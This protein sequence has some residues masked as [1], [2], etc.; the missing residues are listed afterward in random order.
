ME[1]QEKYYISEDVVL[2]SSEDMCKRCQEYI[3]IIPREPAF[4]MLKTYYC[5]YHSSELIEQVRKANEA[6]EG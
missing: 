4:I 6:V 2:F 1:K 5:D 3:N